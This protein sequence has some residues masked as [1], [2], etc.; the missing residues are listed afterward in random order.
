[1]LV[2]HCCFKRDPSGTPPDFHLARIIKAILYKIQYTFLQTS[3]VYTYIYIYIYIYILDSHMAR[4]GA[5][6]SHKAQLGAM[7]SL[8]PSDF[9]RDCEGQTKVL[10]NTLKLVRAAILSASW[11]RSMP[12]P[13]FRAPS[14]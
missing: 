4:N 7:H 11:L 13:C 5:C 8:K 2:F 14:S 6:E 1:M 9:E 12:E 10:S 3:Y